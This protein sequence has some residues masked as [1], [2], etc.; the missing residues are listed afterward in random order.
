MPRFKVDTSKIKAKQVQ[1]DKSANTKNFQSNFW[2]PKEGKNNIRILP[3]WSEE[4]IWYREVPY[5]YGVGGKSVVC[6]KRLLG[7]PCYICDKV[8]EFRKSSDKGLNEVANDL[9]P[10][11]RIYYNVVDLDDTAKGVQVFGSGVQV[12]KD[13]LYYD[14]DDEWGNITDVDE[15]YDI[16]LTRE[17]KGRNSKYQVKAKKNSSPIGTEE[18]LNSMSNLDNLVGKILS[19]D[20]LK[21]LYE[22][23]AEDAAPAI[24]EEIPETTTKTA[25]RTLKDIEE[26]VPE[27]IEEP[28]AP[29]PK[30]VEEEITEQSDDD[31]ITLTYADVKKMSRK[32]M[33]ALI[34]DLG[35]DIDPK[36]YED[37]NDLREAIIE[38]CGL[39]EDEDD[40][41]SELSEVEKPGCFGM[42]YSE[43]DK[44]CADCLASKECKVAFKARKKK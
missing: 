4:G 18:W 17:G 3:P 37:E 22:T 34:R 10:K 36:E 12:F 35:L 29:T 41:K 20:E 28:P 21:T 9:R 26:D 44:E 13:L 2:V 27:E 39:E 19:Y 24:L 1:Y 31:T 15:G 14:L 42:E 40:E 16:I 8:A 32:E 11:M 33:K 43:S 38:E 30:K 7:K 6:P 5:H 23:P 25:P